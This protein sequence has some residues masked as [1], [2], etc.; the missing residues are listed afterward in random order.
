MD[1]R[2]IESLFLR[3]R[4]VRALVIGDLILDE[5][6]WGTTERIS[7]E[8]PVRVVDISREELRLG[9]AGNVADNLLALGCRVSICSVIGADVNGSILRDII[10]RKGVDVSALFEDLGRTT[11]RKTRVLAAHQQLVRIDRETSEPLSSESEKAVIEFINRE[12]DG[13]DVI[14]VSDYLKGVLTDKVLSAVISTGKLHNVPVVVDPKGDDFRKYRGATILTPNRKEAGLASG[15]EIDGTPGLVKAAEFLL[16]H[17]D[18]DALLITKSEEGMSL[19]IAGGGIDHIPAI[20][21]EVYDVTGVGDTVLSVLGMALAA[22]LGFNDA[23]HLANVAAGIA[24]GKLG[25]ATVSPAEIIGTIGDIHPDSNVKVKNLD[26]LAAIIQ[27]ERAAGKQV[28]FTVG[29]FDLLQAGHVKYLQRARAF[30]D[31]LVLGL[32]SDA[33]IRRVKGGNRP[34]MLQEERAH[35][36]A[37]LACVD[38]VVIDDEKTPLR[39]IETLK[40]EVLVEGGSHIF[41]DEDCRELVASY[42]GR[43]ELVNLGEV[44]LTTKMVDN[45]LQNFSKR[46]VT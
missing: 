44:S 38:Y 32:S 30:G 16:R 46:H 13:F 39:L 41:C 28:V 8:A 20:A 42:G 37:A 26:V 29:C 2:E 4:N 40:P 5:Y 9:G 33:T 14:L 36:L 17:V 7:P 18:L 35:L 23:A 11:S 21:R 34:L 31:L 3:A 12:C 10:A 6:L 45:I 24:V 15:I 43:V 19:F 22:G 27:N 1:R 25:T